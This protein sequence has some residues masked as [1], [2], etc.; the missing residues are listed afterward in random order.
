VLPLNIRHINMHVANVLKLLTTN[1]CESM[2]T[3][4]AKIILL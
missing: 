4:H 3:G 2:Q 1:M